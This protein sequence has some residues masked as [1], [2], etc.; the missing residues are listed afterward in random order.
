MSTQLHIHAAHCWAPEADGVESWQAWRLGKQ[1]PNGTE[2][3]KLAHIKPMQR[4]R[5]SLTARAAFAAGSKCI[6]D[7]DDQELASLTSVF[8]SSYGLC[9]ATVKM[10]DAIAA[11]QPTSP[12]AFSISVHNAIAGQF[13]IA[14]GLTGPS[15]TLAPGRDGLGSVLLG[16]AGLLHQGAKKVLLCCFE[17]PVPDVLNPYAESPPTPMASAFLF[18]DE[19]SVDGVTLVQSRERNALTPLP[20]PL[21]QQVLDFTCFVDDARSNPTAQ[22]TTEAGNATYHWRRDVGQ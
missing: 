2:P 8:A 19:A 5:L 22:L 13:S 4:R 14:H 21:W 10:L 16:V 18:G 17:E 3:P 1:L 20:A 12:A 11:E 6:A 9:S 15:C 7:F